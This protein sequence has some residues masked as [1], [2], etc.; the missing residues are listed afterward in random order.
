MQS[1][2]FGRLLIVGLTVLA[3][4]VVLAVLA[5]HQSPARAETVLPLQAPPFAQ[6]K[7]D[8]AVL[9]IIEDEAGMA[10]YFQAATT[11]DLEDVRPVFVTIEVETPEYIIGS[12][13]LADYPESE[14][15]HVFVHVDGWILAYYL[16]A[17]P[18]GKIYDWRGYHDSDHTQLTTK[19][20]KCLILVASYAIVPYTGCTYYHFQY[21]NAT[22]LMLIAEWVTEGTDSFEVKLPG[23]YA[24]YERSWSF[25]T[26]D[27]AAYL[28][29][30]V[31]I[32]SG[33]WNTWRTAQGTFTAGQ[34]LPE[35]FHNIEVQGGGGYYNGDH[36]YA[37]LALVYRV[38]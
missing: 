2:G 20:E 37:G 17:D 7:V 26:D 5:G 24:F 18:V 30:G 1:R 21:P 19:L 6:G 10:G 15:V 9:G 29:D 33:D 4:L 36:G 11:I 25:G 34:L 16:T 32:Y 14:Q 23:D 38:P 22:N 35:Q 8:N 12:V 3:L 13:A 31:T 28:L 27:V